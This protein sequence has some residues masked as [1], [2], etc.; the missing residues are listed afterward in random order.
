[1]RHQ[2]RR[3]RVL[4]LPEVEIYRSTPINMDYALSQTDVCLPL[5]VH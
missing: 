3:Y 1:M 5:V 4:G 2:L